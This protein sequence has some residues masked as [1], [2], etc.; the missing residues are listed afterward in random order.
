MQPLD[1]HWAE[2]A[3]SHTSHYNYEMAKFVRDLAVSLRCQS[4]LEVG[5]SAAND[6]ALFPF[7]VCGIDSSEY[8]ISK[9]RENIPESEFK[10]APAT[11]IPYD[12]SAFDFVF[13]RNLLNYVEDDD[14]QKIMQEM[15][16][17][18]KKYVVNIEMFSEDEGILREEQVRV[19]GRNVRERWMD[20][21]VKIVSNVDM[22]EEIDPNRSRFTLVRKMVGD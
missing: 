16:R 11:S 4:V 9:A 3:K 20:H 2:Y 10:V 6:L 18:S 17:V 7:P 12:D 21:T 8:A 15:F 14:V 22:H 19:T 13:A 5:C 1:R